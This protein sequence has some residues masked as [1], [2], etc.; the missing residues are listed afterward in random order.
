MT[1]SNDPRTRKKFNGG[2][3]VR[4]DR[5]AS[6]RSIVDEDSLSNP[7]NGNYLSLKHAAVVQQMEKNVQVRLVRV[8]TAGGWTTFQSLEPSLYINPGGPGE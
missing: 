7:V 3:T 6:E 2:L 4:K 8:D 5:D 1:F